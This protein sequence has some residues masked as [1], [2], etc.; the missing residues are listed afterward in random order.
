M[1]AEYLR[2]DGMKEERIRDD[3]VGRRAVCHCVTRLKTTSASL[4][5]TSRCVI[6]QPAAIRHAEYRA[7]V[8]WIAPGNLEGVKGDE[9]RVTGEELKTSYANK[10]LIAHVCRE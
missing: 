8:V 1:N 9:V 6:Y 3:F 10:C 4:S 7:F 5:S 2:R